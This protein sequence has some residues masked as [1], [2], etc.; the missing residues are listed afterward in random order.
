LNEDA[1]EKLSIAAFLHDIGKI[2]TPDSILLKSGALTDEERA[3]I[4][5]HPKR[6]SRMLTGIIDM[7]EVA[8]AVLHHH[9]HFDGS[10][11]PNGLQ[12]E[13]IPLLSRI[14][15]VVDAYDAM[16]SPRPFREAYTHEEA[17]KKLKSG[18]GTQFDQ[19]VVRAFDEL[20]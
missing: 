14:I 9:E 3:I 5:L 19:Q 1:L 10:G 6:G 17:L 16:T 20:T 2:A 18:S 15:M 13:E 11:Y 7:E 8:K 4:R 12:G